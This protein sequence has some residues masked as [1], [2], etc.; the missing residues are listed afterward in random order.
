MLCMSI[1]C[2]SG[3]SYLS[4]H[5]HVYTLYMYGV[6]VVH[7]H[8]YMKLIQFA[9]QTSCLSQLSNEMKDAVSEKDKSSSELEAMRQQLRELQE[10]SARDEAE[11][12]KMAA[13]ITR[14]Q[15][16]LKERTIRR[17]AVAPSI[18]EGSTSTLTLSQT[19]APTAAIK[20]TVTTTP[21]ASI[22]PMAIQTTSAPT[23]HVTPTMVTAQHVIPATSTS[24]L[25]NQISSSTG[26]STSTAVAATVFVRSTSPQVVA[27]LPS[28]TTAA[29]AVIATS[30]G[31]VASGSLGEEPN[32]VA[33]KRRREEDSVQQAAESGSGA[34]SVAPPARKRQK[35]LQQPQ[36]AASTSLA[37][38][39]QGE[40]EGMEAQVTAEVQVHAVVKNTCNAHIAVNMVVR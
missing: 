40:G 9:L 20:P 25:T 6:Y 8:L 32:R 15:Q 22:R 29:R 11:L 33:I 28:T 14:L 38:D 35:P 13:T 36:V 16:Q 2:F 24:Q 10:K 3:T 5:G 34:A 17:K 26:V 31:G 23:A 27:P 21:T 39:T 12:K 30:Q 18:P 19:S 37:P 1:L 4:V 7:I